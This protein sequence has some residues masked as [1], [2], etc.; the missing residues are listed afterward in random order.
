MGKRFLVAFCAVEKSDWPRAAM[1]RNV[2]KINRHSIRP[3]AAL[4][5]NGGGGVQSA[6]FLRLVKCPA[7]G[8]RWGTVQF[9]PPLRRPSSPD[10]GE[11]INSVITPTNSGVS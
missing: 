2:A 5:A 1:D 7:Q 11:G 8:E 6:S 4:R 9:I 10:R 3:F